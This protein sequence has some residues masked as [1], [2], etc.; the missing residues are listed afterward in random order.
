M[1]A[2]ALAFSYVF[3][4]ENQA[5]PLCMHCYIYNS[6]RMR[7]YVSGTSVDGNDS[8][9]IGRCNKLLHWFDIQQAK[10]NGLHEYDFGGLSHNAKLQGIDNFKRQFGG[11]DRF[12]YNTIVGRTLIGK[13][14]ILLLTLFRHFQ[15]FR[16]L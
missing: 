11:S 5:I 12:E 14:S 6:D 1:E 16:L 4:G 15:T 13:L 8:Q 2:K 10:Q 3:S 9:L 7:L